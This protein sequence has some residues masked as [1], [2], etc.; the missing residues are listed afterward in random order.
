[1]L[2]VDDAPQPLVVGRYYLVPCVTGRD[3]TITPG[4]WYP[5]TGPLHD[6]ASIGVRWEHWHVDSRFISD[7]R[8]RRELWPGSP[9]AHTWPI[10][11]YYPPIVRPMRCA[12]PVALV[13]EFWRWSDEQYGV[14]ALPYQHS[15]LCRVCPHRGFRAD[16]MPI[17][18]VGGRQCR[19]CPGHGLLWDATT[20]E[21][22]GRE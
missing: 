14:L 18:D 5:V 6:D 20:G 3:G 11:S 13:F 19:V 16:A 21:Q 10:R 4:K 12:R 15:K 8:I 7:A 9:L 2:H 17:I 1:M 22:V